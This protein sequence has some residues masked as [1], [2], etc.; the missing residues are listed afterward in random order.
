MTANILQFPTRNKGRIRKSTGLGSEGLFAIHQGGGGGENVEVF[1]AHRS[2]EVTD[3]EVIG[4]F[5]RTVANS[6][7]PELRQKVK[8]RAMCDATL[9]GCDQDRIAGTIIASSFKSL[10]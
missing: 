9:G 4:Y 3:I 8:R 1:N 7:P 6:L 10:A 5:V 2:G